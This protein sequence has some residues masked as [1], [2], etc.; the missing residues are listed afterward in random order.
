VPLAVED[1]SMKSSNFKLQKLN[2]FVARDVT[3]F[4]TQRSDTNIVLAR[5]AQ[6]L[7]EG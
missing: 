4:I 1:A 3:F 7:E 6:Q 5:R 2:T